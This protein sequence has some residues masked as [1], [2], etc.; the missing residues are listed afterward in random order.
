MIITRFERWRRP[1]I[2]EGAAC[3]RRRTHP[4]GEGSGGRR[5]EDAEPRGAEKAGGG[6]CERGWCQFERP[7][8]VVKKRC[9]G[10]S[11]YVIEWMEKVAWRNG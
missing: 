3:R 7:L 4:R 10:A 8:R 2:H 9:E 6:R 5:E 11:E 1:E